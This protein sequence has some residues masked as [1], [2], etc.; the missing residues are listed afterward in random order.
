[1]K[2]NKAEIF[3]VDDEGAICD[4]Y[5]AIAYEP[6]CLEGMSLSEK[7]VIAN[8]HTAIPQSDWLE[9][10]AGLKF[11]RY[12]REAGWLADED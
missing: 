10:E 3:Y 1:M 6:E 7:W 9:A 8:Y 4:L 12:L 2:R 5:D 11:A